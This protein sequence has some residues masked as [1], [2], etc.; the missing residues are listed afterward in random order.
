[1]AKTTAAPQRGHYAKLTAGADRIEIKA[2]VPQRGIANALKRYKLTRSNDEQ[3]LVYFFDT[4][5][6][7]LLKSGISCGRDG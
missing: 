5:D 2:T 6:Q 4:P 1:M 7:S 3:R